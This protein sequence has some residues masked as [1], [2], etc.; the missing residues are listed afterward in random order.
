VPLQFAT[1]K[2]QV[3]AGIMAM[4]SGGGTDMS[5]GVIAAHDMLEPANAKIKHAILITDG[6][7]PPFDY[8]EQIARYKRAKITFTLVIIHDGVTTGNGQAARRPWRS[9]PAGAIT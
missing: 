2:Q 5:A 1:D 4:P 3:I 7:S 6:A 8:K 9:G